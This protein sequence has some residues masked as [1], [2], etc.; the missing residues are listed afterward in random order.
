MAS[1]PDTMYGDPTYIES[2]S[3]KILDS[4]TTLSGSKIK[5][6]SVSSRVSSTSS[7]RHSGT[8][9]LTGQSVIHHDKTSVDIAEN[10]ENVPDESTQQSVLGERT[11]RDIVSDPPLQQ[12]DPVGG[13]GGG[14][15]GGWGGGGVGGGGGGGG[16]GWGGG[17]VGGGGGGGGGGW[18]GGGVGGGSSYPN[19]YPNL[20]LAIL[21]THKLAQLLHKCKNV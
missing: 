9:I 21:L 19:P 3:I 7:Y 10:Q 4:N 1:K 6:T 11:S 12:V 18:G 2:T 8:S 14:G 16:G 5:F 15:G 20:T 13:G 17:G